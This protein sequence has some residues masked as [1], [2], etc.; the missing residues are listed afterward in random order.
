[1]TGLDRRRYMKGQSGPELRTPDLE[2]FWLV[3]Y[4]PIICTST[5]YLSQI[6]IV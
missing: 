1:M 6:I 3:L 2:H 4:L 5:I